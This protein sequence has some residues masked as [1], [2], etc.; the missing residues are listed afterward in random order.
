MSTRNQ[1]NPIPEL[2]IVMGVSGCGKSTV[3]SALAKQLGYQFLEADDFHS[4][5]NRAHMA[6][7]KALTDA[8]REPWIDTM[9]NKLTELGQN[10]RSCVMSFSGLR[11]AHRA[12]IRSAP[13]RVGTLHLEGDAELIEQRLQQRSDH[14]MP[15]SLL[16]SQYRAL[17][18]PNQEVNTE[19]IDINCSV[20]ELVKRAALAYQRLGLNEQ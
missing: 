3:A 9:L 5:E 7:G 8:M 6:S 14:F 2:V 17:E 18:S 13:M 16:A 19:S 20:E 10:N 4:A 1:H 11:A 12:R 15:S